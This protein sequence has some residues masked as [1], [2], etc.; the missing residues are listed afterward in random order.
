MSRDGQEIA[1]VLTGGTPYAISQ[2]FGENSPDV[3][4]WW[5]DYAADYGLKAGDHPGLD[6]GVPMDTPLYAI[7]DGVIE[8]VGNAPYFRPRPVY[9]RLNTGEQV[10]YG[11]MWSDAVKAGQEVRAGTLL[12]TSGRQT[13][14][15]APY[16]R[17]GDGSGPHVHLEIR[18]QA[19]NRVLDPLPYLDGSAGIPTT[20]S[21]EGSGSRGQ[22][23]PSLLAVLAKFGIVVAGCVVLFFAVQFAAQGGQE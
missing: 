2:D 13:S 14:A 20:G 3:P 21:P 12:G 4:D 5:Y 9:Q 8:S 15:S 18:N 11:H 22:S 16:D 6:I 23:T 1:S 19:G 10:I 7:A 17:Q